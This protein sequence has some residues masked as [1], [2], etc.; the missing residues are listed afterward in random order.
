MRRKI[1]S[2]LAEGI[3][4]IAS[5]IVGM[6]SAR[7]KNIYGIQNNYKIASGIVGMES[8]RVKII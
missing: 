7:V 1:G 6:E 4:K 8:A 5:G 3:C 2:I